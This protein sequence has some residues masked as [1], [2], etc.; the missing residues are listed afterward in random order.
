MVLFIIITIMPHIKCDNCNKSF[1][2]RP[3][4]IKK[5]KNNYCSRKCLIEHI[6]I[7]YPEGNCVCDNCNK[8][9]RTN[10]AYIKRQPGR[11]RFCSDFCFREYKQRTKIGHLSKGYRVISINGKICFEHRYLMEQ[12]LGR[13]LENNE[14]VHH[15]NG[16]KLD[17]RIENL[18]VLSKKD[19]HSYHSNLKN[20]MFLLT[21]TSCGVE[22]RKSNKYINT[23][24]NGDYLL[25]KDFY[26][27]KN[28]YYKSGGGTGR[29]KKLITLTHT[30]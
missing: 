8:K 24:Y 18:C 15:K 27:C 28:C 2:K 7:I 14:H 10:P 12:H 22:K 20:R 5:S 21:C 25:A 9:Y 3:N 11:K 6:K 1:Y 29:R 13:K 16:D 4:L 17:N 30:N 26:Q 19:H 23:K